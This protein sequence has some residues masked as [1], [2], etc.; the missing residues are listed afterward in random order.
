[1][2]DSTKPR[3]KRGPQIPRDRE[4]HGR[5]GQRLPNVRTGE[6]CNAKCTDDGN[7][8]LQEYKDGHRLHEKRAESPE[9]GN[10]GLRYRKIL[11]SAPGTSLGKSRIHMELGA[12]LYVI[13]STAEIAEAWLSTCRMSARIAIPHV[14]EWV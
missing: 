8:E 9:Q 13:T 12:E 14:G 1:M 7:R 5:E 4:K 6:Q 10:L 11:A 3:R 2:E